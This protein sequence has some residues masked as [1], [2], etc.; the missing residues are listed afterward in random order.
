MCTHHHHQQQQ[1]EREREALI[2][3]FSCEKASRNTTEGQGER[4]QHSKRERERERAGG[5]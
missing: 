3:R 4:G 5:N 2:S 1:Q